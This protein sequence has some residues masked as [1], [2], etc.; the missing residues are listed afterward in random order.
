M[1]IKVVLYV[2]VLLEIMVFLVDTIVREM[3]EHVIDIF[4][5]R[6]LVLISA[7]PGQSFFVK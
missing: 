4:F 5:R 3:H 2:L 1:S 6:F 7:E